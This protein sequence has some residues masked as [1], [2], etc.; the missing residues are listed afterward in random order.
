MKRLVFDPNT[1]PE[2]SPSENFLGD[3][4]LEPTLT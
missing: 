1:Y 2:I 4:D 3:A